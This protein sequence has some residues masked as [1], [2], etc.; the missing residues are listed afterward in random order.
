MLHEMSIQDALSKMLSGSPSIWDTQRHKRHRDV[1]SDVYSCCSREMQKNATAT[2]FPPAQNK[3][4]SDQK[5]LKNCLKNRQERRT[6]KKTTKDTEPDPKKHKVKKMDSISPFEKGDKRTV[7]V[8]WPQ[9]KVRSRKFIQK[10]GP[11]QKRIF[12]RH[13]RARKTK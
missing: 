5:K 8:R 6:A 10:N 3:E 4:D 1:A 12:S 11:D 9:T 2:L 7:T 13:F